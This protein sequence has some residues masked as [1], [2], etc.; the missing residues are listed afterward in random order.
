M[1]P[2]MIAAFAV[3]FIGKYVLKATVPEEEV[4]DPVA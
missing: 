1:F 4:I 2:G 3:F